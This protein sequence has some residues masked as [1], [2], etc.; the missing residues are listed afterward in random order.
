[1]KQWILI[2]IFLVCEVTGWAGVVSVSG[3]V[4]DAETKEPIPYANVVFKNTTIGV[5]SDA[6]GFYK[7]ST[8][9]KVETLV[10]SA[11]GYIKAEVDVNGAAPKRV[12]VLLRKDIYEINE[13]VILPTE[14]P[15]HPILRNVIKNKKKNSPK[16][17]DDWKCEIYNK[18]QVDLKNIKR[19]KKN[20]K[21]FKQFDFVFDHIDTLADNGKTYLPAFISETQSDFY[22]FRNKEDHEIIKAN[23]ASGFSTDIISQFSGQ[24]YQDFNVYDNFIFLSDVGLISPANDQGLQHYRYYLTD[25][26]KTDS[27]KRYKLTFK[28]KRKVDPAFT[29]HMWVADSSFAIVSAEMKMDRKV[30]VNF[31]RDFALGNWFK[32]QN[33]KWVPQ[34]Q[35]VFIDLNINQGKK[36]K[37][38]GMLGRK[39]TIY[40]QFE[41]NPVAPDVEKMKTPTRIDPSALKKSDRDWADIRPE[42]LSIQESAIYTMVDSIQNVP[43]F[44]TIADYAQ[45]FVLGY[46][47]MGNVELGPYYYM[48]S[49][50]EVEGSRIRLG[51]RTLKSFH[52]NIR[53]SGFMAYGFDDTRIKYGGGVEYFFNKNPLE[54]LEV[55][56]SHDYEI[57]GQSRN[58]FS[59][60][61]ILS[62]ILSRNPNSSLLMQNKF[63]MEYQKEWFAGLSNGLRLRVQKLFSAPYV[64]FTNDAGLEESAVRTTELR[65]RTR[66]ALGERVLIGDF[67]RYSYGSEKPIVTLDATWGINNL[68]NSDYGFF[69]LDLDVFDRWYLNPV[70]YWDVYL[71]AG[72][73]WGDV[74]FPLLKLHEANETYVFDVWASSLM[75]YYEF[76]SDQYASLYVEHHMQGYLFNRVPLLRKLK[77]REVVGFRTVWG[78]LDKSKHKQLVFPDQMSGLSRKPYMEVSVGIE[79]IFKVLRIDAV[80]RLNYHHDNADKYGFR[81]SVQFKF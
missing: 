68:F 31:V 53:L 27:E 42:P 81:A 61:N 33:G 3:R 38:I 50:N 15:A 56:Y 44:R 17:L 28:P 35:Y 14:N 23:K 62:T 34:K 51:A 45:M 49:H 58:A 6:N 66:L 9:K 21:L 77:W 52:E 63:D 48:Y 10:V 43:V 47:E 26:V 69:K 64:P 5:M 73:I 74:P 29:G 22:H 67:D 75:N 2:F 41:F 8:E 37:L 46:K 12:D 70:G 79:N 11:I 71:M 80:K 20:S 18:I 72:K 39:T 16:E 57:L 78:D 24:F 76:V 4:L 32:Q 59:S 65:F 40:G 7:L 13:V 25:S 1:M 30:N 55:K 54:K 60:S 36:D 19:P